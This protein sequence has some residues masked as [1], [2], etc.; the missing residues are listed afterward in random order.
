MAAKSTPGPSSSSKD[1]HGSHSGAF[2]C[3]RPTD[4]T[5]GKG[6]A[7]PK[8]EHDLMPSLNAANYGVL[9]DLSPEEQE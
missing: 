1:E 8:V 2:Q 6:K 9:L 3:K 4:G 7:V 5:S